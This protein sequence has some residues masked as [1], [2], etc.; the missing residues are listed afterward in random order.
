M[1]TLVF[2]SASR[3]SFDPAVFRSA[4]HPTAI[5]ATIIC[6]ISKARTS[7]MPVCPIARNYMFLASPVNHFSLSH[8]TM[9]AL[10]EYPVGVLTTPRCYSVSSKRP[11]QTVELVDPL[12]ICT[13]VYPKSG[14]HCRQVVAK[15]GNFSA[16]RP[17]I[18]FSCAMSRTASPPKIKKIF[19]PTGQASLVQSATWPA[20][21]PN[22][23]S[24]TPPIPCSRPTTDLG[25][26]CNPRSSATRNHTPKGDSQWLT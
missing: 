25:V 7:R 19:G 10:K 23:Q 1:A 21:A 12:P 6:A 20:S 24:R 15:S 5:P 17:A 22:G 2:A 16:P 3:S 26:E 8:L 11:H 4:S 14:R 18:A 13:R 9:K